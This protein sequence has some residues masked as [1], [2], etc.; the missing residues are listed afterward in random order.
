MYTIVYVI[1]DN[2]NLFFYNQ[3][4][5]SLKSLR[6]H[7]PNQDVCVMVDQDTYQIL[8]NVKAEV[9][10]LAQVM[11]VK[12][13]DSYTQVEKS[14]FLKVTLRQRL[15][16][17]L[18]FIDTDTVIC[19]VLPDIVSEKSIGMVLEF[20]ELRS[21]INWYLTDQYD[22]QSGLDLGNF[23]Y[24]FNSGV[25]WS[26]DDE[27]SHRFYKKW[28]ELWE[29]TRK[30]GI[31]RDQSAFN[32]VVKEEFKHIEILDGVWNCQLARAFSNGL[33]YLADA[34]I[35]HYFNVKVSAYMLCQDEYRNLPYNDERIINMLKHPKTLFSRCRIV[36]LD[37]N[38]QIDGCNMREIWPLAR[39]NQYKLMLGINRRPKLNNLVESGLGIMFK[40]KNMVMKVLL[41]KK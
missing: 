25:V 31:P 22:Q 16:G 10:D 6:M 33:Q 36:K 8:Q 41:I 40:I 37:D 32:Y 20:H 30:K 1:A 18:L 15:S 14:R 34:H 11:C 9:F 21:N 38:N 7:M 12:I 3:M 17:N 4:M 19:D 27:H 39:T 5:K 26:K 24:F 35:I 2:E 29:K 23:D 28:H 13:D